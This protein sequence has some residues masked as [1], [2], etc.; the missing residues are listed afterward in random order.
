MDPQ[1][2]GLIMFAAGLILG[3]I[4]AALVVRLR[5]KGNWLPAAKVKSEYVNKAVH[6]QLSD[7]KTQLLSENKQKEKEIIELNRDLSALSQRLQAVNEKLSVQKKEVESLQDKFKIEFENI[8]NKLL[9][10]KSEKFTVQNKLN[11]DNV[12]KPLQEK[13]KSFEDKVEKVYWEEA[14]E[15]VSLKK[16]IEQLRELNLQLSDDANNL[17]NA[18]KGESKTQGDWGELRLEMLLEKS[19]L[20]QEIHFTKQV[21]LKDSDGKIKR[22]DFVIHLPEGKHLVIDSKVSLTAYESFF[23]AEDEDV[24]KQ[25]LQ[26]HLASL[27]NHTKDLSSKNYHQLYGI[28]SPDYVLMYIP[29][30][31]AFTLA[32]RQ[33]QQLFLDALEKNIVMVTTSTLLATLRTVSYI[34]KQEK[35]K[36]SVMEIARQSGL[37]YDKLCNF[38]NDLIDIGKKLDQAGEAYESAMGKLARGKGNLMRRAEK[39]RELGAK[40]SKKLPDELLDQAKEQES[41]LKG[42]KAND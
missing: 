17:A 5:I 11:L 23:N 19:G 30:E 39:I 40:T 12:L 35:Q 18:L 26:A 34:W 10:E 8:A 14:K 6:D 24:R 42:G 36:K 33:N 28:N 41:F 22:P 3:G 7:D 31:S 16:E 13:I 25:H 32:I 15:R 2:M 21:S 20:Q 1:L 9:E 38:V 37:L 29:I 4:I 27:N